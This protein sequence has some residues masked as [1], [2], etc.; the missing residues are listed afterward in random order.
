MNGLSEPMKNRTQ[1]FGVSVLFSNFKEV[2]GCFYVKTDLD[3]LFKRMKLYINAEGTHGFKLHG[4]YSRCY[5]VTA[6]S[7]KDTHF[8]FCLQ[9]ILKEKSERQC[10]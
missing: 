9:N 3:L 4:L 10:S 8:L 7:S 6:A 1:V 5:Q 2:G